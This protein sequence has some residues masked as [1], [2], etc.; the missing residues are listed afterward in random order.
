M[1][2]VDSSTRRWEDLDTDI[3]VKIFQLLDLFELTS[4]IAHVC[5]AWR[6]ACCDPL[7]WKTL[8]LSMLRSNFIK[9]PLEPFVY[10]DQRSDKKLTRLLK[11]SLNLSKQSIL[12]L[13]FHFNLYVSDDQLTY[14]AERC[15]QLKRLVLPAWNRIKRTGMCKAIRCWKELE[16]L[17]MPSIANPPYFLEEIATH[18][19]NFRELKIMGPC[20]M[21]FASTLATFVPQLRVLSIRCTALYRDALILIL[22]SLEHLEV[23]N[24][25]HCILIEGH[26]GPPSQYKKVIKKIDPIIRQKASRL[27]E[28]ITC[29]ED[30]CIMC[31]RTRTDEGIVRWYKYEEW[32]WKEDEVKALAL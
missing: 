23:L 13:I 11:I 16:S 26:P 9:I 17:T 8:D 27:R 5:S 31:Q 3:L 7:L 4:G 14:T 19:K 12:T 22:D 24:I 1:D 32:F 10:V 20:D 30:L 29:M 28:F 6:V 15:P 18:C 2:D 21:F 25:S